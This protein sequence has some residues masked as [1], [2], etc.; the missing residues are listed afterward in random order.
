MAEKSMNP[1]VKWLLVAIA[2][3]LQVALVAGISI[4]VFMKFQQAR[5]EQT[6]ATAPGGVE[7]K[8]TM[9]FDEFKFPTTE[10]APAKDLA[11]PNGLVTFRVEIDLSDED[12]KKE[13]E[14]QLAYV[15]DGIP[16]LFMNMSIDEVKRAYIDQTL[17]KRIHEWLDLNLVK[18][19]PKK[20][21]WMFGDYK[22]YAIARVNV[23]DLSAMKME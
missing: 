18:T 21:T 8:A 19:M 6:A 23:Y 13:F 5:D 2:F 7:I 20:K 4:F 17:H 16:R 14:R 3:L 15:R 10:V 11:A 1:L 12:M 9:R 22:V